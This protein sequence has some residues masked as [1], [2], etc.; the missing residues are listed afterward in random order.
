MVLA[1]VGG[2]GL[3]RSAE[4]DPAGNLPT[5]ALGGGDAGVEALLENAL[6]PWL[7]TLS[8]ANLGLVARLGIW[9]P[10]PAYPSGTSSLAAA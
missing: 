8:T 4:I 6:G 3:F 10:R 9:P 2:K 1:Y 5:C 7:L